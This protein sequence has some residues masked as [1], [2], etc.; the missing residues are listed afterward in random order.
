MPWPMATTMISAGMRTWSR[1]ALLGLGRPEPST[2]PM[3]WGWTH[4]ALAT[5]SSSASMRTGAAKVIISA[6]SAVAPATSSGRAVISSRRRRYT[7]LT[8]LAPRRI[9][10]RVTSIATLPPPMT[11]TCLPVK[12][13]ITSS[14]IALSISTADMTLRLSSPGMP[15]FLSWCAPMAM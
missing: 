8:L 4:R 10:L 5:P 11:T 7:Q 14:P 3:I 1:A 6:P 2:S 12:S 13:G 15:V 9:E